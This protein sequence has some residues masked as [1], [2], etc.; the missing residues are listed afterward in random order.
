MIDAAALHRDILTLDSH[1]DIPWPTSPDPFTPTDRHVDLPKMRAGSLDAGC[2]VAFV[3]QGP[4]TLAG[5]AEA[6][7]RAVA[8][9]KTIN[10]MGTTRHGI[11]ARVC[12][13]A[14]E[15]ERAR[16]GTPWA[17]IWGDWRYYARLA[18]CM[19]R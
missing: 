4:L 11:T 9:L 18:R 5:G 16:T 2:F 10:A 3:P 8:M 13:T 14:D 1:I 7:S 12:P 17:G 15:I 19:S 6:R